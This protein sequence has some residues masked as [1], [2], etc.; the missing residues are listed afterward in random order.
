MKQHIN[1]IGMGQVNLTKAAD[2]SFNVVCVDE[3]TG[4]PIDITGATVS[5][6]V[7]SEENKSGT[8]TSLAGVLGTL[9]GG[10][11]TVAV[12]DDQAVIS[13]YTVGTKLYGYGKVTESGGTVHIADNPI[14]LKVN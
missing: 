14:I 3:N 10:H 8:L 5:L 12:A 6:E 9:L 13:D 7:Y 1:G 4:A 2:N 11:F